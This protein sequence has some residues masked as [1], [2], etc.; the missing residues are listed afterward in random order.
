MSGAENASLG[1]S[2]LGASAQ[3]PVVQAIMTPRFIPLISPPDRGV[4][5]KGILRTKLSVCCLVPQSCL[6]LCDS[7]ACSL[8]GSSVCGISQGRILGGLPFLLPGI[9]LTQGSNP[10]SPA[11]A[12]GFFTT[13]PP[14]KHKLS[15]LQGIKGARSTSYP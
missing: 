4:G 9:F 13:E 1:G 11:S 2:T 8:P 7:M 5:T 6:T 15:L 14:G 12:G 10:E 3:L